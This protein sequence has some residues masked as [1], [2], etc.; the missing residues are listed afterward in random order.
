[1][2][3]ITPTVCANWP[4]GAFVPP[5]PAPLIILIIGTGYHTGR[6]SR[7]CSFFFF[8]KSIIKKLKNRRETRLPQDS[9]I[10]PDNN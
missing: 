1:M 4:E 3:T 9:P 8:R 5:I 2:G 6:V 10:V 7:R